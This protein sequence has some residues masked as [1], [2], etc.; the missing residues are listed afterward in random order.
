MN[1][2]LFHPALMPR[3]ARAFSGSIAEGPGEVR[4]G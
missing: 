1:H 2:E 4:H 3:F